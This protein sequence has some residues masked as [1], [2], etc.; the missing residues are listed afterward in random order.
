MS[1]KKPRWK[2][3]NSKLIYQNSW[4]KLWEDKVLRPDGRRDIY[5]YFEKT[6]GV[7]IIPKDTDGTIFLIE[8]YRYPL[9]KKIIQLPAGVISE[10]TPLINAKREL[11][12]E[13]GL[14]A[15]KWERLGGFYI[16]PGHETTYIHVYLASRLNKSNVSI[17]LEGDETILQILQIKEKKLRQ[18]VNEG[19]I[20]CG[21]TLA[22]LNLYFQ[23][24]G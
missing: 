13:T 9:S 3:L 18:M 11:R 1:P 16:A 15:N 19:K 24:K 10:K 6:Q 12:E 23:Y 14:V 21:I 8:E 5:S 20:E 4:I 7:F 17:S 2:K 22:A